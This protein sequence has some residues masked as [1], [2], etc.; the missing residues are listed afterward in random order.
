MKTASIKHDIPQNFSFN[1]GME[2]ISFFIKNQCHGNGGTQKNHRYG[3]FMI[4]FLMKFDIPEG[5]LSS[6]GRATHS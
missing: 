4:F 5:L 3:F 2:I 1:N 6:V